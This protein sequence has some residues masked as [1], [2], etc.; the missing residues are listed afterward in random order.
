MT[1]DDAVWL[2]PDTSLVARGGNTTVRETAGRTSV[3]TSADLATLVRD[4]GGRLVGP[5]RLDTGADPD[6]DRPLLAR[7]VSAGVAAIAPA[8]VLPEHLSLA[9]QHG[10]AGPDLFLA[11]DL[12]AGM[13]VEVT[14]AEPA[15]AVSG[16][17]GAA[18]LVV[19]QGGGV[20]LVLCHDILD[21]HVRPRLDGLWAEGRPTVLASAAARFVGPVIEPGRSC[22]PRCLLA[23]AT[24][25]RRARTT[26]EDA[27]GAKPAAPGAPSRLDVLQLALLLGHLVAR[28]RLSPV[29]R[30]TSPNTHAATWQPGGTSAPVA[31]VPGAWCTRCHATTTDPRKSVHPVLGLVRSIEPTR[32]A[33]GLWVARAEHALSTRPVDEGDAAAVLHAYRCFSEGKGLSHEQAVSNAAGEVVERICGVFHDGVD[34]VWGRARD[35]P[36]A[37]APGAL[38]GFSDEQ[39]ARRLETNVRCSPHN[40]VPPAADPGVVL[41]WTPAS[42][43]DGGPPALLPCAYVFNDADRALGVPA[44]QRHLRADS[45]GCASAPS[46]DEA[47]LRGLLELVERDAVGIWWYNRLRQPVMDET[48]RAD[49]RVR[50]VADALA[51]A[52]R[53]LH[54]LDLTH[55]LGVPVCAAVAPRSSAGPTG[56]DEVAVGFGAGLTAGEAARRACLEVAQF[57]PMLDALPDDERRFDRHGTDS[58][59]WWSRVRTVDEPWLLPHADAPRLP[60]RRL[61]G[62]PDLVDAVTRAGMRVLYVDQSQPRFALATVRVVVPGLRHFWRRLAPGRLYTVPVETGRLSARR[63]EQ[64][65]NPYN[66]YF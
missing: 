11:T 19:R 13:E 37:I 33:G 39:Y 3:I 30:D 29:T 54:L 25:N 12:L 2:S 22:C 8:G 49:S 14:G 57:L 35:L 44:A 59:R 4:R 1:A 16:L 7:L 38:L 45:N 32:L 18:G 5:V 23:T 40:R 53:E 6:R 28:H 48:V 50:H 20:A 34:V 61:A 21:D 55:D 17:L 62:L 10:V 15:T 51:N 9:H 66:V 46:R 26:F 43:L 52:D 64:D 58:R 63:R 42:P 60:T 65:L 36:T 24:A 56:S 27:A 47:L 31:I 41:P